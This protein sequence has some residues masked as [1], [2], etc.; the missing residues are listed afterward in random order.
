M[1]ERCIMSIIGFLL[2]VTMAAFLMV[3]PAMVAIGVIVV[4]VGTAL[5]F[6]LGVQVGARTVRK[7]D[8]IQD[9]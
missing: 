9:F 8:I 7:R 6:V 4:T 5:I 2:L 3:V 1:I